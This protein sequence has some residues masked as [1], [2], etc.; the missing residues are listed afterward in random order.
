MKQNLSFT[1]KGPLGY[2]LVAVCEKYRSATA[3]PVVRLYSVTLVKPS[4][5]ESDRGIL[6]RFAKNTAVPLRLVAN[7]I[8]K[9]EM[10]WVRLP[11]LDFLQ[12]SKIIL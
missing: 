8:I 1:L 4:F 5:L 2:F 3:T 11:S 10:S 12:G 7:L 6:S 9:I